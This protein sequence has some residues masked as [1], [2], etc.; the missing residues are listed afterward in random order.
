M[1]MD[2]ATT[3]AVHKS[4]DI[5]VRGYLTVTI[6]PEAPAL[7]RVRGSVNFDISLGCTSFGDARPSSG[8]I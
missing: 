6:V 5:G 3:V 1:G 8:G 7:W 4:A 2:L